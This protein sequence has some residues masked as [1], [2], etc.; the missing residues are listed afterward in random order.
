M[1]ARERADADTVVRVYVICAG[2]GGAGE[3]GWYRGD[4]PAPMCRG[5]FCF[6]AR[7]LRSFIFYARVGFVPEERAGRRVGA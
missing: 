1:R 2:S 6:L 4:I 3:L 5:V 7:I